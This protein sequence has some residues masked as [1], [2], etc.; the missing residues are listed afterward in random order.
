MFPVAQAGRRGFREANPGVS[1]EVTSSSTA[2]G[3]NK[4]CAGR[5]TSPQRLADQCRRNAAMR[6]AHDVEFIELPVAF[7]SLSV[8]VHADEHVRECLTVGELKKM[9]EPRRKAACAM[10]RRASRIAA[11][12][13]WRSSVRGT[14]PGTYDYFTLAV[15]GTQGRSRNDYTRRA[16]T[17][18]RRTLSRRTRTRWRTSATRTISPIASG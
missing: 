2:D 13:R 6:R 4:L 1:V 15:V 9:W 12:D 8:V 3:F 17:R 7:D 10:E 5:S 18:F 16:T 14:P 11:A